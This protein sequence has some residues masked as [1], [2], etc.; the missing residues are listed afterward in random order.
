MHVAAQK[1]PALLQYM[2]HQEAE[3]FAADYGSIKR[4]TILCEG[5]EA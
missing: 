3:V 1:V 4:V 5:I 2:S